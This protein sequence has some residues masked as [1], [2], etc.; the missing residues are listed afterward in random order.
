[1]DAR[2]FALPLALLLLAGCAGGGGIAPSP[3]TAN[4]T[5]PSS[6]GESSAARHILAKLNTSTR[7]TQSSGTSSS[8]DDGGWSELQLPP[9]QSC[10]NGAVSNDCA[11]WQFTGVQRRGSSPVTA[12][13]PEL[14]F[15][16]DPT[17]Y[18]QATFG[19]PAGAIEPLG[20]STFTLAYVGTQAAPILTAVTRPSVAG[21]SGS[22]SGTAT[23]A[24]I[25]VTSELTTTAGR[26]W[27][28]FFTWNWPADVLAIPYQVNEIQL[29]AASSPIGLSAGGS[30]PLDAYDCLG[31]PL[32]ALMLGA[33]VTFGTPPAHGFGLP[34]L[35][36]SSKTGSLT[37]TVSATDKSPSAVILVV[38]DRFGTALTTVGPPTG[39]PTPAPSPTPVAT[40]TPSPTPTAR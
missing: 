38:D 6:P 15:C 25:T 32:T 23:S 1:M 12:S 31:R 7:H 4:Q 14:N 27:I 17:D 13:V 21:V 5:G 33:G 2:K 28:V 29:A 16:S 9:I 30:A 8:Y 26:G 22:F 34:D 19:D 20:S 36:A 37:A 3:G 10:G 24:S 18:P 35:L 39:S 40:P 11:N